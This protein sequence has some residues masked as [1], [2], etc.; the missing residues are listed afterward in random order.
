MANYSYL[1]SSHDSGPP[2][3][4]EEPIAT[5]RYFIP[6]FWIASCTLEDIYTDVDEDDEEVPYI[7]LPAS[8]ALSQFEVNRNSLEA[9]S[10]DVQKYYDEWT[11]LL[12]QLGDA[13]LKIDPSEVIFMT[14]EDDNSF[15][16][17]VK[18]FSEANESRV[19]GLL[20]NSCLTDILDANNPNKLLEYAIVNDEITELTTS[21]YLIG[22]RE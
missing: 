17:A 16:E 9:I 11:G 12:H 4:D 3:P 7:S 14:E 2:D 5:G 20:R 13:Q 8:K 6:V 19:N 18:F 10:P 21:D 1:Y 22:I 15:R